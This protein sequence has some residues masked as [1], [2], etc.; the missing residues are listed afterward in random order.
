MC[1]RSLPLVFVGWTLFVWGNRI[2]NIFDDAGTPDA[3][4][5]FSLGIGLLVITLAVLTALGDLRGR[6]TWALQALVLITVAVWSLRVPMIVF[7]SDHE[8]GFKAVH[9]VIA[10]ISVGLAMFALRA[11]TAIRLTVDR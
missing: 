5:A 4:Q 10:A 2:T 6:P 9:T 8:L 7:G 1:R 3:T 11:R